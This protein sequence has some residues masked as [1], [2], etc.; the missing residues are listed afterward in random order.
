MPIVKPFKALRYNKSKV[1]N[2][3][4]VVTPPYDVIPPKMQGEL[5][6]KNKYNAVRIILNKTTSKD[7]ASNNRYTRSKK[8][9]TRWLKEGVLKRDDKDAFYVYTQIYKSGKRNIAQ[10][11]F[12]GLMKIGSEGKDKVLPHENTLATPKKDRLELTRAVRGN[13]EPIFI[14]HDDSAITRA[15]K[16]FSAK[17]KPV[18]DFRRE[19]VRHIIRK[20]EDPAIIEMIER[21]MK[22]KNVFIA[23]G[24]HRYEVAKMY[25]KEPGGSD[26]LMV[27]FVEADEAMLTVLP[28]HR[29]IK[30]LGKIEK[31][32]IIGR[33]KK[34]F[35]IEKTADVK[36]MILRLS[37]LSA[38]CA[39]GMYLGKRRFYVLKLKDAG[40]SDKVIRD[41]PKEWKRLDVSILHHFVLRH[42][43]GIKD[44]DEN[45]EF[46]K[47]PFETAKAVDSNKFKAAFFLNPTKVSQVKRIAKLGERMPRKSTYFYPKQISGLVINKH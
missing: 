39:F 43:L 4:E 24:H 32:D 11:G 25:S 27:Y 8:F 29:L 35:D 13:L 10:V 7:T 2:I 26:H 1:R 18:I 20:L 23:D 45:I 9:L 34:H 44:T 31:D 16:K 33:L 17:N 41:K 38:G 42:L 40:Q 22:G 47:D 6:R 36:K 19:G 12:I 28:T 21:H 37:G 14:L 5:Y 15:L 3:A 46:S 30:D